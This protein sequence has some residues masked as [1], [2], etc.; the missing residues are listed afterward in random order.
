MKNSLF[1]PNRI[2]ITDACFWI[3]LI[4][5]GDKYHTKAA[6]L[7]ES[8]R[9][10]RTQRVILPQPILY[11]VLKTKYVNSVCAKN[12]E[13][14]LQKINCKF[15]SDSKYRCGALKDT[16][17]LASTGKRGISLVDMII[18]SMVADSDL[19]I[20]SLITLNEKDLAIFVET[21]KSPYITI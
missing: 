13:V 3:A 1:T 21:T 15:V 10:S 8:I 6:Q 2:I 16:I 14:R 20:Q 11:E 5:S 19:R 17:R 7:Y 18:R 9:Q 12:F 4:D